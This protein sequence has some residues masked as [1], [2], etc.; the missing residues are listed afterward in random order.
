MF[1]EDSPYDPYLGY[2]RSKYEAEQLVQ[3][4]HDRGDLATVIVRAPWFYGPYQPPR[5]SQFFRAIRRGR[6]P[7]VGDGTQ[8][9]SMVYTDNLV[10][11]LLRAEVAPTRRPGNAYWV[12][13]A[14]PYELREILATVRRALDGRGPAHVRTRHDPAAPGRGPAGRAARH[15]GCRTGAA[16]SS[17]CTCSAS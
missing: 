16:T 5:Q 10:Q 13:D 14:E 1:T 17:R 6:F 8:R 9:R 7:L 15:R 12:A 11:G 2:G 3:Q 4:A